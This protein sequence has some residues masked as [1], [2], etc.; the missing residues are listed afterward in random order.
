MAVAGMHV[1]TI[2]L[3]L[4]ARTKPNPSHN[5]VESELPDAV[6]NGHGHAEEILILF[7][8]EGANSSMRDSYGVTLLMKL[9]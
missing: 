5:L 4:S 6:S 2:R 3:L 1:E 7:L 9:V 8:E